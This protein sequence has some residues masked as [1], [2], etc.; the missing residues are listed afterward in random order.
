M[1]FPQAHSFVQRAIKTLNKHAYF[2][3]NTFDYYNLSNGPLEG[4]N[5]KIKLIKRTSFGY[6]N[7]NHLHNRILLCS[8][9][10]LQKGKKKL[11]NV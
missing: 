5:N 3:K 8:N 6:G 7:Y 4:I 2:I 1:P 11:S 9:F 10:T